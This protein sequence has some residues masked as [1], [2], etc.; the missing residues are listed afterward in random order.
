MTTDTQIEELPEDE[1]DVE[2]GFKKCEHC[3]FDFRD[4]PS[5]R[6][7]YANH[8]RN[9]HP[10]KTKKAVSEAKGG[11]RPAPRRAPTNASPSST[12]STESRLGTDEDTPPVVELFAKALNRAVPGKS[13]LTDQVV[14][15]FADNTE[16]LA[17]NRVNLRAWLS[18]YG[19]TS[20]QLNQIEDAM[21]GIAD[22]TNGI[23]GSQQPQPQQM[24]MPDGSLQSVW[25]MPQPQANNGQP[26]QPIN[27]YPSPPQPPV[28]DPALAISELRAEMK[29]SLRDTVD[30]MKEMIGEVASALQPAPQTSQFPMRRVPLMDEDGVVMKD[31]ETSQVL[32]Q[33]I[34]MDPN[35]TNL[36]MFAKIADIMRP[37]EAPSEKVDMEKLQLQIEKQV[38]ESQPE[39]TVAAAPGL[40]PEDQR[41]FESMRSETNTL[42]QKLN[43]LERERDIHQAIQ[44]NTA[45]FQMQIDQLKGAGTMSDSQYEMQHRERLINGWQGIFGEVFTGVRNDVK[46]II[47]N[48]LA[49]TLRGAG[50]SEDVTA[51][52]LQSVLQSSTQPRSGALNDR[53]QEARTKWMKPGV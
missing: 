47:A 4:D 8:V 39:P 37:H 42:V 32:Y 53:V 52:I 12:A 18:K 51:Q 1:I 41:M 28:H 13:G 49:G 50:L 38:R 36:D 26:N 46:P 48:N 29:E 34:P 43:G 33:E 16:S 23:F 45:T 35:Q 7:G 9:T 20:I 22:L 25:V 30:A 6:M 14:E 24:Q 15:T 19:L 27:F 11:K 21:F 17:Q 2:E 40:S 10:D 5:G 31:P 3:D 44:D